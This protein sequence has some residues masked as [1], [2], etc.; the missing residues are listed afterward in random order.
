MEKDII[1]ETMHLI[2]EQDYNDE[3]DAN[4]YEDDAYDSFG[5]IT[6]D[7]RL[8][9][10]SGEQDVIQS[11]EYV[12][13]YLQQYGIYTKRYGEYFEVD[14]A[15]QLDSISNDIKDII[16]KLQDLWRL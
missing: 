16:T 8:F 14:D 11:L 12:A 5:D 1:D 15:K 9:S 2:S 7:T 10:D 13:D 3:Y 6:I 4:V